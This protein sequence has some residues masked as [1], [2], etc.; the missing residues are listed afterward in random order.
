AGHD[1]CAEAVRPCVQVDRGR[2]PGIDVRAGCS[3]RARAER[4]D[5]TEPGARGEIED[6]ATVDDLWV[7]AQ[8]VRE[9]QTAAPGKGPVRQ[10]GVGIAGLDLER[11][12]QRKHLVGEM[13]ADV[14]ETREGSEAGVTK[15][16]GSG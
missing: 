3:C 15:D 4:R 9:R 2:R 16:E 5:R 11:V 6:V 14:V 10:G 8:V 1:A 13:Q 12:P 7:V